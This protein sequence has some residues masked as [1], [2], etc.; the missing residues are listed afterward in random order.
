MPRQ[1]RIQS[2]S[3]AD[4]KRLDELV[5]AFIASGGK[6]QRVECENPSLTG[7]YLNKMILGKSME[8]VLEIKILNGNCYLKRRVSAR[9]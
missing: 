8:N 6:E 9:E 4:L 7:Y 2:R 5:K 1:R 3:N